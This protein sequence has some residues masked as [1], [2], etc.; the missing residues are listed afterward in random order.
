MFD[1]YTRLKT[2]NH[3]YYLEKI[4]NSTTKTNSATP[5]VLLKVPKND[6]L[7]PTSNNP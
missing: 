4:N 7:T 5:N 1:L 3:I 6:I 2:W